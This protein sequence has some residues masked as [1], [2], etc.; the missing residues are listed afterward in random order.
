M[1]SNTLVVSTNPCA[2]IP[3]LGTVYQQRHCETLG[4]VLKKLKQNFHVIQHSLLWID[5]QRKWDSYMK[6]MPTFLRS[7]QHCSQ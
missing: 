5:M 4:R 2:P 6:E 1:T 7:L 3:V